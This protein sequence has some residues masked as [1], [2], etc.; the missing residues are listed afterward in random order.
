MIGLNG[1]DAGSSL[2]FS[3]AGVVNPIATDVVATL[4]VRTTDINGGIIDTGSIQL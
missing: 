3:I 2:T 1:K 4:T